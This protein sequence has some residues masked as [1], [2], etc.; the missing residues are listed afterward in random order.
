MVSSLAISGEEAGVIDPTSRKPSVD[1]ESP[2]VGALPV[3]TAVIGL[4]KL[5]ARLCLSAWNLTVS[6]EL[7]AKSTMNSA[8]S[9]VIMSA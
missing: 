3:V 8:I 2:G 1:A 5:V 9:T 7:I 6:T 4:P